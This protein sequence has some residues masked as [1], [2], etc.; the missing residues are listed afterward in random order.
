MKLGDMF[1]NRNKKS[2]PQGESSLKIGIKGKEVWVY[3]IF[4]IWALINLFPVYWMFTF[5]LKSNKEIFGEN[6]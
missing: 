1:Q 4:G 2:R 5:S 3:I 6:V